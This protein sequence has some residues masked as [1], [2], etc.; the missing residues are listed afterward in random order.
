MPVSEE[1]VCIDLLISFGKSVL[2]QQLGSAVYGY[3]LGKRGEYGTLIY[4]IK[5]CKETETE[6]R[7]F[8]EKDWG[9]IE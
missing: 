5:T 2:T 6:S 8:S 1:P 7:V 4:R 3:R 9:D